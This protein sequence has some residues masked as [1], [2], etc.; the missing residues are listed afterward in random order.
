MDEEVVDLL[1][2]LKFP[3]RNDW[4]PGH[5][6]FRKS[7][8]MKLTQ[9]ASTGCSL[10]RLNLYEMVWDGLLKEVAFECFW[11]IIPYLSNRVGLDCMKGKMCVALCFNPSRQA[12]QVSLNISTE[13][14]RMYLP[15]YIQ[16]LQFEHSTVCFFWAEV[17]PSTVSH[18]TQVKQ[19][20]RGEWDTQI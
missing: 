20:Y 1:L 19:R 9:D 2:S 11:C 12:G 17:Q 13:C 8:L 4:M 10:Y 7:V 3:G 15:V 5:D 6:R 16:I 14:I 18:L